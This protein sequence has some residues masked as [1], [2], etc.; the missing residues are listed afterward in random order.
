MPNT[1]CNQNWF[2]G[3]AYH[4]LVKFGGNLDVGQMAKLHSS[5]MN[6]NKFQIMTRED[7]FQVLCTMSRNRLSETHGL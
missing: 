1:A 2:F 5:Q 6:I 7:I 3:E 4:V